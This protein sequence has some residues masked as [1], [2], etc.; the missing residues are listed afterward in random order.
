MLI[1]PSIDASLPGELLSLLLDPPN[2]EQYPDELLVQF[3]SAIRS[4]LLA[5][6]LVFDTYEKASFKL[7]ND[8][9][10]SLKKQDLLGRFLYF[11][12]DVLGLSAGHELRLDKEG[13]SEDL[14]REYDIHLAD[15]E[16]EERNM[17]WLLL[18]LMFAPLKHIPGYLG[19]SISIVATSRPRI[20]LSRGLL[21]TSRR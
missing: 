2:L 19:H 14:V 9:S 5:W 18:H 17:Q 15:A 3:P 1:W 4:Y 20:H 21:N 12:F 16:V 13:F 10:E 11:A 6:H 7:R 8:Y